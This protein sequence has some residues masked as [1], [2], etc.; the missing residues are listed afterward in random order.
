MGILR[1]FVGGMHVP[2]RSI[3]RFMAEQDL[4]RRRIGAAFCKVRGKS[5]AQRVCA[6]RD[7]DAPQLTLF[8]YFHLKVIGRDAFVLF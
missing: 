2:R 8:L 7:I 3:E 5:V 1:I 6:R 4:N